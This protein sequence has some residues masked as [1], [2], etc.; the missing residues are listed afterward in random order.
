M[1]IL[2]GLSHPAIQHSVLYYCAGVICISRH[3]LLHSVVLSHMQLQV[4]LAARCIRACSCLQEVTE[5]VDKVSLAMDLVKSELK[6]APA[7]VTVITACCPENAHYQQ[8]PQH[9][10]DTAPMQGHQLP[11]VPN[12][13]ASLLY[14]RQQQSQGV[15]QSSEA[16]QGPNKTQQQQGQAGQQFQGPKPRQ[17]LPQQ[18]YVKQKQRRG[19]E[20][21]RPGRDPQHKLVLVEL[22][23]DNYHDVMTETVCEVDSDLKLCHQLLQQCK[24]SFSCLVSFYGENAHAF[25]ND[26]VFWSDVTTFVDRFTACQKQLRKQIQVQCCLINLL[27]E[28]SWRILARDILLG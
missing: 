11:G 27:L 18:Q 20:E 13:E 12:Q 21:A 26:A 6:R 22:V 3:S 5:S 16:E 9:V 8:A 10:V 4:K 24:E 25:A 7:R 15:E 2:Q 1:L 28:Q 17:G 19:Q 14:G 23:S